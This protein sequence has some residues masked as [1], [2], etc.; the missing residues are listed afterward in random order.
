MWVLN[1]NVFATRTVVLTH[2]KLPGP[3]ITTILFISQILKWFSFK[4]TFMC[5]MSF[6][7]SFMA[8]SI[9]TCEKKFFSFEK[10]IMVQGFDILSISKFIL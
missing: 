1:A 4:N 6:D 3:W 7:D 8:M 10:Q 9:R 2:V 5:Q